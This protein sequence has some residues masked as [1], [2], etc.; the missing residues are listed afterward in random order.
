MVFFFK[1]NVEKISRPQR[2]YRLDPSLEASLHRLDLLLE[3]SLHRLD[4]LLETSLHR[5]ELSLEASHCMRV[6][7]GGGVWYSLFIKNLGHYSSH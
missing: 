4:L 6:W 2:F 3:P 7:I 1:V 5:L